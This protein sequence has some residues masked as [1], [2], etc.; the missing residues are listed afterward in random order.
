MAILARPYLGGVIP[1]G[2]WREIAP[3]NNYNLLF[4]R[5]PKIETRS[6]VRVISDDYIIIEPFNID[7]NSHSV[8][9]SNNATAL[10]EEEINKYS[11]KVREGCLP[12][13][14]RITYR[15]NQ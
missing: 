3:G 11:I 12:I 13:V 10:V 14:L 8:L 15:E 6:I 7:S 1:F 9:V 4:R 5:D 2:K